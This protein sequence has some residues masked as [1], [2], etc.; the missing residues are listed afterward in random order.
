[1]APNQVYLNG[2][3]IT[4]QMYWPYMTTLPATTLNTN[5]L[6]VVEKEDEPCEEPKVYP[7]CDF[8]E[9]KILGSTYDVGTQGKRWNICETPRCWSAAYLH[10]DRI[11]NCLVDCQQTRKDTLKWSD[12]KAKK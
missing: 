6:S 9:G 12:S 7:P 2:K 4:A 10:K 1:M 3:L 11:Y 5:G 8:C